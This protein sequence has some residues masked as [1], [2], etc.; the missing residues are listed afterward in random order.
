MAYVI[1]DT[2]T[3]DEH[4][5]E[6]CPVACIHPTKDEADFATAPQLYVHPTE[7]VDCGACITVCPTNS[8]MA[9]EEVPAALQPFI[10]KNAAYFN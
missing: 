6:A 9:L 3:K 7:C 8:I 10:E 4:C 2:C 1:T 5:I